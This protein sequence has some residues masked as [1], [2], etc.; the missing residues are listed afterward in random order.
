M[1]RRRRLADLIEEETGTGASAEE[2]GAEDVGEGAE[3]GEPPAAEVGP[4]YLRL[5]RKDARLREDQV[6]TLS[7]ISRRMNRQK[8]GKGE[9]ITENTLIRVG[10]DLLLARQEELH[11]ATEEEIRAALGLP[12]SP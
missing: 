8:K 9:R 1:V 5:Q 4:K 2:V 7:G 10:V 6:L 11:G 3:T 12:G